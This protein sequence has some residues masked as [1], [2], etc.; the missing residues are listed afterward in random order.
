MRSIVYECCL[1]TAK[2]SSATIV[3]IRPS[4]SSK[5]GSITSA[6][7]E[8]GSATMNDLQ[9]VDLLKKVCTLGSGLGDAIG[10]AAISKRHKRPNN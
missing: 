3:E 1:A 4:E 9:L 10:Q 6:L 8:I 7:Q 5:I 2:I